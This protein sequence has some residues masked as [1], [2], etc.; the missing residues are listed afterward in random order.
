MTGQKHCS[1]SSGTR[2]RKTLLTEQWHTETEALL[3]EF[4]TVATATRTGD[5]AWTA[6]NGTAAGDKY[7]DLTDCA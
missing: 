4:A 2:R 3:A 5:G 7:E 6:V 1:Q